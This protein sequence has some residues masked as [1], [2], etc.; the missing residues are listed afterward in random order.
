[1][2]INMIRDAD[3]DAGFWAGACARDPLA[4]WRGASLFA[5][6][7]GGASYASLATIT[8]ES[9]M[10]YT[11]DALGDFAGGNIPDELNSVNVVLNQGTLSSIDYA[12]LLAGTYAAVIGDEI[13]YFRDATLETNGSYTLTGFLRGRRGSEY[14]MATHAAADRFILLNTATMVRVAQTTADIGVAKL[15]KPVGAGRTLAA[16][17]A[18][19]FTNLGTGLKPYSSVHLG[20]GRNA[21]GDAILTWIPRGRVDGAWRD[22]VDVPVGEAS[23]AYEVDILGA[24]S[25]GSGTAPFAFGVNI[26]E[27]GS[28]T[29]ENTDIVAVLQSRGLTQVRMDLY[30][31]PFNDQA[32]VTD[33]I[34]K[35]V[36]AG[37]SVQ[38]VLSSRA[39]SDHTVYTGGALAT[40]ESDNFSDADTIVDR[41]FPMGVTDY[42]LINEIPLRAECA[43]Q[44]TPNSGQLEATYTGQTAF[45]SIGAALKGMADAVHAKD[46]SCRVILGTVGRDWG[47]LHYMTTLGVNWDVLGYHTYPY[48]T[49][50]NLLTDTF[51]GTGGLGDQLDSFGKPVTINEYNSGDIYNGGY[52]NAEGEADT[53]ASWVS[54]T[55]H[56]TNLYEQTQ[57]S[58]LESLVFY[59]LLDETFKGSPENRFG[60]MYDLDTPKVSLFLV[61]AFAGGTL[62]SAER[63]ELTS[64]SLLDDAQIDAMQSGGSSTG[65]V[66]TFTGLTAPTVT[67][68]ASEQ[69]TDFGSPPATV[70]FNVYKMSAVVGRGHV[71]SG[72]V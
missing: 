9:T 8:S 69:T 5:S 72:S 11:T 62:S 65:V 38:G 26:H 48:S 29:G 60:L 52:G 12:G 23:E 56:I 46:A 33:I 36:A 37:I 68:L 57:I 21:D 35:L 6:S 55:G 53:E 50:S 43:A 51:F 63:L 42:E 44:V 32:L 28:S 22:L 66:R 2:N 3:N 20:G 64:R 71:A 39:I 58:N 18:Q 4:I 24:G 14:A 7:D 67:Y 16:T 47:F 70:N 27:G 10:G 31:T 15:F 61:T 25:G 54:L 19:S 13:L 34:T 45:I 30:V 59:E 1:V 40:W 41:Y 17:T 49:N